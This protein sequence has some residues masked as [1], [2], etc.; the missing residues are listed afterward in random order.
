MEGRAPTEAHHAALLDESGLFT[1]LAPAT[2]IMLV[3]PSTSSPGPLCPQ[4]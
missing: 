4:W 3:D 1:P 2:Y